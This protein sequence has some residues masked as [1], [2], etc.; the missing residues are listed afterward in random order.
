MILGATFLALGTS[1]G[2]NVDN[3]FVS[4]AKAEQ[5]KTPTTI[6]DLTFGVKEDKMQSANKN[7]E[8]VKSLLREAP[9]PN[10]DQY[11]DAWNQQKQLLQQQLQNLP[12]PTSGSN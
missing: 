6:N 5:A 7:A 10:P 12:K 1:V 8:A 2:L 11:N 4:P 3:Y 9:T